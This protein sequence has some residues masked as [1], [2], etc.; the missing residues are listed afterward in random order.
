[1][2]DR[3]EA[4]DAQLASLSCGSHQRLEK[5]LAVIRDEITGHTSHSNKV[6]DRIQKELLEIHEKL[7]KLSVEI[8]GS[9]Q[10]ADLS[11]QSLKESLLPSVSSLQASVSALAFRLSRS[12]ATVQE[13]IE[14]LKNGFHSSVS[15]LACEAAVFSCLEDV[16]SRVENDAFLSKLSFIQV[17]TS[18][19]VG[20]AELKL[21]KL[22]NSVQL[23]DADQIAAADL[24]SMRLASAEDSLSSSRDHLELVSTQNTLI[25]TNVQSI[26][27]QIES[28]SADIA[29]AIDSS[30]RAE[31]ATGAISAEVER[32]TA[33][34]DAVALQMESQAKAIVAVEETVGR[35]E[36]A[37]GAISAEVERLTAASDAVALQIE[38]QSA[39]ISDIEVAVRQSGLATDVLSKSLDRQSAESSVTVA[40]ACIA[41]KEEICSHLE[42]KLAAVQVDVQVQAEALQE[43]VETISRQQAI[44]N[45]FIAEVRAR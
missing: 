17:E 42:G 19:A 8:V 38:S 29:V 5:R 7:S 44:T 27:A 23:M 36:R 1:M 4:L 45:N 22:E 39:A 21:R 30:Q 41:L 2:V 15:N 6:F 35:A 34:S 33:A 25:I 13:D 43:L 3:M 28:Q 16:V 10:R 26:Q 18:A 12:L 37:T 31:R 9:A 11:H 20:A 40:S 24:F 14:V 32:L